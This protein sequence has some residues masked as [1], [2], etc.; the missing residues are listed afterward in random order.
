MATTEG[1]IL[2]AEL[3]D[4]A[5][6]FW[7]RATDEADDEYDNH[8]APISVSFADFVLKEFQKRLVSNTLFPRDLIEP[9]TDYFMKSEM[10][11]ASCNSLSDLNLVGK[12]H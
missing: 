2:N 1:K 7:E 5:T 11:E 4:K 12:S 10:V 3:F 8:A 9:I 6:D